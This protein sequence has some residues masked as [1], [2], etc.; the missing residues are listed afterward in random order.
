MCTLQKPT[1]DCDGYKYFL[2]QLDTV[3]TT[4]AEYLTS[5][6]K[7]E[8]VLRL[9]PTVI[10]DNIDSP[11]NPRKAVDTA[12]IGITITEMV[13]KYQNKKPTFDY[14]FKNLSYYWK[15]FIRANR[16]R[17]KENLT[18]HDKKTLKRTVHKIWS[19]PALF[20]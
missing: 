12:L 4:A 15:V 1:D 6:D 16:E 5:D 10:L 17:L 2:K 14:V 3:K 19:D 11:D 9:T 8:A 18:Q 20:Y 13:A 7:A